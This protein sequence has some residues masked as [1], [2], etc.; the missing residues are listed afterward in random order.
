MRLLLNAFLLLAAV[1]T[2]TAAD[3]PAKSVRLFILSGQSNM[4]GLDPNVSFTPA[5]KAA[6]PGDE[7]VVVK[8]ASS[9]Q[10]IR[11]W[12]KE[13]QPAP[14]DAMPPGGGLGQLYDR[15]LAAV[16]A[17]TKDRPAPVSVVFVW[18]QGE[19]DGKSTGK[20]YA[21]SLRALIQHLRDDLKRPDLAFV[22]GRISDYG[23]T[24]PGR[25][26]WQMVREAQVAVAAADP[27]GAWIDTDDLNGANNGLH[28]PK[29]GYKAMGERFAAKAIALVQTA[30]VAA[31]A[32]AP[33]K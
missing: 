19:A 2:A 16:T 1:V 20:N 9:G 23:A 26:H 32:S 28:Y 25:A 10:P 8:D 30:A 5:L 3:A 22:I 12:L 7:I 29:D 13:W 11:R 27:R 18:M 14:G 17:A 6:F 31:P 21:D 4:V 15:L 24:D 33:P